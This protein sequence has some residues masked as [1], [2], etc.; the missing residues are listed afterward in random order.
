M[1]LLRPF[2]SA[3]SD[4]FN[5]GRFSY[6]KN[7]SKF[8]LPYAYA[9]T[10]MRTLSIRVGNWCVHWAYASGTDANCEHTGQELMRALSILVRN[11]CVH[12]AYESGTDSCTE[13]TYEIWKGPFKKCW[14]YASGT[15]AYPY[16]PRQQLMRTLSIRLRNWCVHWACASGTDWC[17]SSACESEIKLCIAPPKIKIICLYF[18]PK[19]TTPERPYGV[20][21]M[22]IRAIENLTL[23]T[24]KN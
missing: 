17:L 6:S 23:G 10:F 4:F 13:R 3:N 20:K 22:K 1:E 21:I 8:W 7:Y 19:V 15:S 11:W 2:L 5:I 12:W 16:L 24:F 18:S 9:P 14:A